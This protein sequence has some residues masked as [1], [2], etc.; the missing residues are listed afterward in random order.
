MSDLG[1]INKIRKIVK[2]ACLSK[3]N[4]FGE[5]VWDTHI[6]KVV[7]YAK[8]LGEQL[9]ADLE[10]LEIAGL[11]HDY[12]SILNKEN[13]EDHHIIGADLAG[14]ILSQLGYSQEKIEQVQH[15]ILTHRGSQE[16]PRKTLEAK[17]LA[18]ADALAHFDTIPALLWVE[19][20]TK[21]SDLKEGIDQV[22]NKL[23]RSWDKLN[24]EAQKLI[25]D[26]YQAAK[27]VLTY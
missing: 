9:E 17:I 23:Q 7:R 5:H 19:F 13:Y 16:L 14:N 22:K 25:T 8:M 15:C 24:P 10:I 2:I 18:N 1:I 12:A 27:I 4:S 21:E 11:L 6:L 20:I 3:R 26:K